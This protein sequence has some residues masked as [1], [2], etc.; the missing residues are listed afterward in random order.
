MDLMLQPLRKY[1]EFTGRA[2][3][4]EFW[5]FWLFTVVVGGIAAA[6]DYMLFPGAFQPVQMLVGLGLLIPSLAV[7][8]RRLHDSGKSAWWLLLWLIPILGWI[9]LL[10]FYLTPGTAGPNAYGPDPKEMAGDVA[11]TFN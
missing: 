10:I 4:S 2:R 7:A 1:A 5:L 3:R 9:A 6:L 8:F 11:Q